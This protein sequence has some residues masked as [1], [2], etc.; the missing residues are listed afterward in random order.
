M[1]ETRN[2]VNGNAISSMPRRGEREKGK[3]GRR[4][5]EREKGRTV[6]T[7]SFTPMIDA[8]WAFLQ[9]ADA[10]LLDLTSSSSSSSSLPS[11]LPS[12]LIRL[13]TRSL[14]R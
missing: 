10:L 1:K 9:L 2:R 8:R 5:R 11:R 4:E 6:S 12:P 14:R 13:Q 3:E 7:R